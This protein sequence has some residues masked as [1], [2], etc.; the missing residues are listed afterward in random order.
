MKKTFTLAI[1][2]FL[3][4]HQINVYAQNWNLLHQFQ[5]VEPGDM[6][7]TDDYTGF[8]IA[9]STQNGNFVTTVCIATIDGGQTWSHHPVNNTAGNN[10]K[11]Y[12]LNANEGFI[13]GRGSGGNTGM[14]MK[15]TDGGYSW[16]APVL[17]NERLHNVFFLN[18]STG[19]VMGKNGLLQ[20]TV[21]GGISWT[22]QSVTTEDGF[23]MRFFNAATGLLSC[24]GG[25]LYR[26][27]DGGMTW[28]PVVSASGDNLM[29]ISIS[30]N[31]AWICGEGG[32]VVYSNNS[33][34]SWTAQ[35]AATSLD[36]NDLAFI[37]SSE[38]WLV[39]L[40]GVMNYTADGGNTWVSQASTSGAD[41]MS[42][43]MRNTAL[44]WFLD[45]DGD[46]YKYSSPAGVEDAK[47]QMGTYVFP[48]PVTDDIH[49]LKSGVLWEN[50]V[51]MDA[52]G[53]TLFTASLTQT[54]EDQYVNISHL[55]LAPGIYVLRLESE[56]LNGIQK[57]IKQ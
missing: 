34:Q 13:A 8:I 56:R 25:E 15:T 23:C 7:F 54:G 45:S 37:S 4:L 31:A 43:E 27:A 57:L 6:H 32:A 11:C 39:G 19:W 20:K 18:A 21:D 9:D 47:T 50:A 46:L 1:I 28:Q 17:F 53:K 2:T 16:S 48:N 24:G 30:G 22:P 41:I 55:Q 38:G 3:F 35:T 5:N 52:G 26:T 10:F 42:I 12:F 36:F 14:F 33:G 44:G 29:S 49:I 51:L 40:N